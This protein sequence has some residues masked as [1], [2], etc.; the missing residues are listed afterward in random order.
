MATQRA[1]P[2]FSPSHLHLAGL[3]CPACDQ[4]ISNDKADQVRERMDARERAASEAVSLRLREQFAGERAQFE[5]NAQGALEKVIPSDAREM[6]PNRP[7]ML[8]IRRARSG[9]GQ[10][11]SVG[12]KKR[13]RR[14]SICG[15]IIGMPTAR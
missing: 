1:I 9:A 11:P 5:A 13:L 4:P 8:L 10:Y 14:S 3:Q 12:R 15:A 6:S 7:R 2:S